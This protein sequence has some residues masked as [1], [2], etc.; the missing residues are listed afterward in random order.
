MTNSPKDETPCPNC[1]MVHG[2][3]CLDDFVEPKRGFLCTLDH[4]HE[5]DHEAVLPPSYGGTTV[6]R[7]ARGEGID[8]YATDKS[9]LN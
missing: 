6:A 1:G 9:R 5:G 3:A 4:G 2:Q 8:P 7:W